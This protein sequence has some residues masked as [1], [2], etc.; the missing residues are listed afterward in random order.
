LEQSD[1]LSSLV[2]KDAGSKAA[3]LPLS[4]VPARS[5]ACKHLECFDLLSHLRNNAAMHLKMWRCPICK[6][7]ASWNELIV[8]KYGEMPSPSHWNFLGRCVVE[9]FERF[10]EGVEWLVELMVWK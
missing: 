7:S 1:G 8:D 4:Q 6:R 2:L 9:C 10:G 5:L 3:V